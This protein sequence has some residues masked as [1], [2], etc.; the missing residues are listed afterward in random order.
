MLVGKK[1]LVTGASSGIGQATC[2]VLA[3]EG[4]KICANGRN[5]EALQTLKNQISCEFVAG[6]LSQ[7]G[8]C[9][10]V[11]DEAAIKLGGLTT[12][13][14]C[15]GVLKGGA[16]GTEGCNLENLMFNFNTNTKVVFEMI[17]HSIPH[18]RK[19]GAESGP[20]IVNVSSVNGIM[21]FPGCPS[22]CASKA[23]VD[24]LTKCAA[25]DLAADGIRVNA[26]N[27]G[28]V[29][30]PLQQRGGMSDE[31]YDAFLKRSIEVTHP[32]AKALNRIATPEEVGELIAF[33][34]S[35]RAGFITG[36]CIRVDG[37]RAIFGYR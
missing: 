27:P 12:L 17:Q 14:N 37:A 13:I 5:V 20:A 30:T 16:F 34:S 11:V 18:L 35:S 4:A 33:L 24:M 22:Y 6:D 25:L 3:R 7:D 9:K 8:E 26:V 23:A 2:G 29:K 1:I 28:V 19:S 15:A 36:D 32:L 10:R 21:S 31:N